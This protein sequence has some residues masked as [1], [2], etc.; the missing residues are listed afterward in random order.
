VRE[1]TA[2]EATAVAKLVVASGARTS[3]QGVI[4]V[5]GYAEEIKNADHFERL[6]DHVGRFDQLN[7]ASS[8]GGR[9]ERVNERAD[10]RRIHEDQCLEVDNQEDVSI[11]NRIE[12]GAL[13]L[14]YRL[15]PHEATLRFQRAEYSVLFDVQIHNISLEQ[16]SLYYAMQGC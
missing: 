10:P 2:K 16:I 11:G 5:F 6:G 3:R 4:F 15:A 13:K 9:S 7:V 14:V 1:V 12:I 8:L